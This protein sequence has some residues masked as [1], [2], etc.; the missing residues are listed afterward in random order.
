MIYVMSDI[1][2]N[3]RRFNSIM[4]QINLQPDDTLY[5]L[6][7]VIDRH[8]D[9]LRILRRIMA[10]PNARMLLGNH[11]L[12]MLQALGLGY[13]AHFVDEGDSVRLFGRWYRN[14][15]QVTHQ[16]WKHLKKSLRNEIAKYLVS[17][18]VNIDIT[19]NGIPYK[20]AHAEAIETYAY[21]WD[22]HRYKD[23]SEYAVWYRRYLEDAHPQNY[24][25]VFGHTPTRQ[26]QSGIPMS[27]FKD[28]NLI[29][30]DCGCGYP[31]DVDDE[32]YGRGR[33]AC[34]RLDDM[35]EFYSEEQHEEWLRRRRQRLY[36]D[37]DLA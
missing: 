3:M 30:I 7:D 1:H 14:G 17:L 19:V 22:K 15:G 28:D 25:L 4:E 35:K 2:G 20:L 10:M 31:D 24:T 34:L 18:P 5:I 9:G 16:H 12:M 29:G 26:F 32:D 13:C 37:D 8:P 11:E 6:G 21:A 23:S 36:G 27:I 33:L